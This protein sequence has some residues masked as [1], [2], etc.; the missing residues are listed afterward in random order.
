MPMN[1]EPNRSPGY[2]GG[3]GQAPGGWSLVGFVGLC[4]LVGAVGGAITAP[5]VRG[6]YLS[7]AR[8]PGT[9]PDAAFAPVWTALYVLM[10]V[11]AWLVWRRNTRQDVRP[12][13]RLWGWQL[14]LN[15][16]WTPVFFGLHSPAAAM[17]VILALL[18][19]IGATMRAFWRIEAWAALLLAPYLAWTCYAAYLNAGFWWLNGF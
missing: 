10:G 2:S 13:L 1:E 16:V 9:P 5:A 7:L 15:A 17:A 4:L 12:A 6:W 3:G 19:L 14:G 8:P 11:A 18:V